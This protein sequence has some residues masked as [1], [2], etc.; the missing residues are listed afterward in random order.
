[1]NNQD[2]IEKLSSGEMSKEKA[3]ELICHNLLQADD[4]KLD[5]YTLKWNREELDVKKNKQMELLIVF[6]LDNSTMDVFQALE[7]T[8]IVQVLLSDSYRQDAMGYQIDRNCKED[9]AKVFQS[10]PCNKDCVKRIVY[11]CTENKNTLEH[12]GTFENVKRDLENSAYSI[13]HIFQYLLSQK[14]KFEFIYIYNQ[15]KGEQ[16]PVFAGVSPMLKSIAMETNLFHWKTVGIDE[17]NQNVLKEI[18]QVDDKDV[19]YQNGIRTVRGLQEYPKKAQLE[20]TAFRYN[21]VYLITGGLGGLGYTFAKYLILRYK[22]NIV[23]CGRSQ[24][25]AEKKRLLEELQAY[26]T[27]VEYVCCDIN[28]ESSIRSLKEYAEERFHCINGIIHCAGVIRDAFLQNKSL[29]DFK[30]VLQPKVFGTLG[31][32]H[33][34]NQEKLDFVVLC[35][36]ISGCNGN[37]GQCDYAFSNAVM[38]Q[39]ALQ[40]YK[41]GNIQQVISINWPLWKNGGLSLDE[42]TMEQLV[43]KTGLLPITNLEGIQILEYALGQKAKAILPIVTD[44]F[45]ASKHVTMNQQKEQGN[46]VATQKKD[47]QIVE[48]KVVHTKSSTE[49]MA[50]QL[51]E[52]LLNVFQDALKI[53]KDKLKVNEP[54]HRY[55][56]DSIMSTAVTSEL[57]TVFT[58]IPATL[59]FECQ[60]I[61]ELK[62]YLLENNGEEVKQLFGVE[63]QIEEVQEESIVN[64]QVNMQTEYKNTPRT[65]RKLKN[66]SVEKK[67]SEDI[68]IIGFSG[69]FPMADNL[70]E[71]WN[72][73]K[74]G[75]NCVSEIPRDRWDSEQYYDPSKQDINKSFTKWG[76]FLNSVK[77]FDSLFF[78]IA[79]RQAEL[80]DPQERLLI[81]EA[82]RTIE[83]AGYTIEGLSEKEV[84]V[85][86]GAMYSQYQLFAGASN[87][88]KDA[89]IPGSNLSAFANRISYLFNFRGPSLTVDSMC[90]SVFTGIHLACQAIKDDEIDVALVGG[91]NLSIHPNKFISLSQTGLIS[92]TDKSMSFGKGGDGYVV[93]EGVG[94]ILL[95]K[96]E[97]AEKD[98]DHIYAVIKDCSI[99]HSGTTNGYMVPSPVAQA[100]VIG[101]SLEKAK[102]HPNTI[103]YVEAQATGSEMGD[104]LEVQALN[105][106]WGTYQVEPQSCPIG[107]VKSNL[108]HL[109]AASGIAAI[110]KV[111]MQMKHKKL[112]PTIHAEVPNPKIDFQKSCFYLQTELADWKKKKVFENGQE[113]EIVRRAAIDSFGAGGSYAHMILD[114]YEDRRQ[115]TL[116]DK[117]QYLFAFSAKS[118]ESLMHYLQKFKRW[119]SENIQ[120]KEKVSQ[121][122]PLEAIKSI[123][124]E[125]LEIPVE[126]LCEEDALG[127]YILELQD[128]TRIRHCIQETLT[129]ALPEVNQLTALSIKELAES[130]KMETGDMSLSLKGTLTL[131]NIS[132]TLL[133]GREQFENRIAFWAKDIEE[134]L[135]KLD[136]AMKGEKGEENNEPKIRQWLSNPNETMDFHELFTGAFVIKQSI[137]TYEFEKETH[138]IVEGAVEDAIKT[139]TETTVET[140]IETTTPD[141]QPSQASLASIDFVENKIKTMLSDLL[142]IDSNK[143]DSK[144]KLKQYGID[145]LNSLRFKSMVQEEFDI[146]IGLEEFLDF[147]TISDIV[148]YIKLHG[149]YEEMQI[150]SPKASTVEESLNLFVLQQIQKGT[151]LPKEAFQFEEIFMKLLD[152]ETVDVSMN[153]SET[154]VNEVYFF[155]L[156]ELKNGMITKEE[157]KR[158]EHALI[159]RGEETHE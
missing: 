79:P 74:D 3:Y 69:R 110:A 85:Y 67:T 47:V 24:L 32:L 18:G 37:V 157:I 10:L 9:Y 113:H 140:T 76:G 107:T 83:D 112:V 89:M 42:K 23:L 25:N 104:P 115:Q 35:S 54:F 88:K 28:Q 73:I 86:V 128:F 72:K 99:Y 11:C 68:A 41:K 139:T 71:F 43:K 29:D 34:W 49:S 45:A 127:D 116:D 84:G 154:F 8:Q 123:I 108:G 52:H 55:G 87:L 1:M 50:K 16:N 61:L 66:A 22:A 48:R 90:S 65:M 143:L 155:L 142:K 122:N 77:E 59:L 138:W 51:E 46:N 120:A 81:E 103:S 82:W 5:Y 19:Q 92:S 131:Q 80:M 111:I 63:E 146:E 119:L 64:T 114:E 70:D 60:N 94:A 124:G 121:N 39:I 148:T 144:K 133:V 145:S 150:E 151:L 4:R 100:R 33:V 15:Q 2:V 7:N 134:L 17:W 40:G 109:E 135:Q 57:E 98:G 132:Y 91:V 38:D 58:N 12:N 117:E 101:K 21:G 105:K 78:N 53:P 96:L 6:C 30:T 153:F 136:D 97:E 31:L 13:F 129:I 27:Q 159:K 106:A 95:K 156:T 26:H 56:I 158:I 44:G 125:I 152:N 14:E 149:T 118:E 102:I 20:E 93:G 130:C 141:L 126:N 75:K 147:S 137:P 62:D 36:S